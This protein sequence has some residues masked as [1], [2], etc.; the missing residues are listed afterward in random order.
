[1]GHSQLR[2]SY[3][4]N[5]NGE[6]QLFN[7]RDLQRKGDLRGS[8]YLQPDH[9]IDWNVFYPESGTSPYSLKIDSRVT[10]AAF[11]LPESTIPDNIKY[12]GNLPLRNL[13]RSREIQ[14]AGGEDLAHFY[15]VTTLRPS[16]IERDHK[17]HYLFESE[18]GR[19]KTPLWYYILKEA[20]I[21]SGGERLGALR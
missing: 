4:L 18:G 16:Q 19:F 21:E 1:M 20:E 7:N 2:S 15:G 6:I 17:A 5:N 3:H 14:V 8:T 13:I 12:I 11:D 9:V 10:H